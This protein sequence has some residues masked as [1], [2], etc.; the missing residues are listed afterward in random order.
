VRRF[1]G[2]GEA[3]KLLEAAI[4]HVEAL[5]NTYEGPLVTLWS[6]PASA[7]SPDRLTRY[8]KGVIPQRL[9]QFTVFTMIKTYHFV[10]GYLAGL[11]TGNPFVLFAMARSQIELLAA[12]Y[13]PVSIIQ[14]L[15]SA[16]PN[17]SSVSQVDRAL[18]KFLHGNRAD[19]I[20]K[21]GRDISS[22]PATAKEDWTATNIMTLIQKA[23]KKP[24]FATLL[25]DYEQLCE[26][27][28]PNLL[29]NFCLAEPFLRSGDSWIR[30]HRRDEFVTSRAARKTLEVMAE[31]TDATINLV[32]LVQWPFGVDLERSNDVL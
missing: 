4:A 21:V 15:T 3:I 30:I 8:A 26:Y 7:M 13:A 17:E 31:W 5:P 16:E 27:L 28:H 10:D 25:R 20:G 2:A 12:A 18:V 6:A 19:L 14:S 9:V 32:N 1:S 11:K 24:E 29:S 22:I 23:S